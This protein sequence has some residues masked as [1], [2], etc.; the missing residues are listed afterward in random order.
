MPE[1]QYRAN[2]ECLAPIL[3]VIIKVPPTCDLTG[4]RCGMVEVAIVVAILT[5]VQHSQVQIQTA[6]PQ[7]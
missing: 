1:I 7:L 4:L 5:D 2:V 3:H 6:Y